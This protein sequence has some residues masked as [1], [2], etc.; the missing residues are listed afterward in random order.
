M[1]K[2]K[3]T[4]NAV[5]KDKPIEPTVRLLVTR[6]RNLVTRLRNLKL[7][8]VE[9]M[10]RIYDRQAFEIM[11]RV[12]QDHSSCIDI[13]CYKGQFLREFI[14][15]ASKGKHY[16]FE[17][18]P[19]YSKHLKTQFPSVE[20]VEAAVSDSSGD[21]TFYFMEDSPARSGL[22]RRDWIKLTREP[23]EIIVKT[24]RLDDIIPANKKIDF[25]K[26]D[27]EGAQVLVIRGGLETIGRNK[28]FVLFEHGARGAAEFG[29]S[30]EE[31]YD[32][33]VNKCGLKISLLPD[34]L[35]NKTPFFSEQAF[36]DATQSDWYFI[37]HI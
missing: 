12:L 37:A 15:L 26:I 3:N 1:R 2:L 30:S 32:L 4:I 29:T 13:G 33:I 23:R 20:I 18:I 6:L 19:S 34:W 14:R 31:L 8:Q 36:I 7:S 35:A 28:P 25:L 9:R 22:R 16:A 27:V 5:I 24:V 17:P 10:D 21:A 11:E